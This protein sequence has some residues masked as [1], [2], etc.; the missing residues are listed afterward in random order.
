MKI[1]DTLVHFEH[2]QVI[3]KN[4]DYPDYQNTVGVS[5]SPNLA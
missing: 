2:K 3:L 5:K 4:D 1:P